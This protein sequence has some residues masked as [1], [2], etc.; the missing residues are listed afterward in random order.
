MGR[1]AVRDVQQPGS[2]KARHVEANPRVSL[3]LDPDE[4]GENVVIGTGRSRVA[5]EQPPPDQN[6]AFVEKYG[7]GFERFG[8]TPAADYATPIVVELVRPAGD[9]CTKV[10]R[11]PPAPASTLHHIARGRRAFRM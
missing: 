1:R 9:P 10:G 2:A 5:P 7:W 8:F 11:S 6:E 4:W 3:H